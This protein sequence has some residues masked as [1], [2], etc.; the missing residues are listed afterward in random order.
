MIFCQKNILEH[1]QNFGGEGDVKKKICQLT[2]RG[3]SDIATYK[4]N[5]E[6]NVIYA[7]HNFYHKSFNVQPLISK[8]LPLK[9]TS[10]EAHSTKGECYKTF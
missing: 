9:E 5:I 10:K 1:S 6:M 3:Q 4:T 2:I 8:G 7:K